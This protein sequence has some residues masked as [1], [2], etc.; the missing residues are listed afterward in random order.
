MALQSLHR[1]YTTSLTVRLP[2]H[3]TFKGEPCFRSIS[4]GRVLRA[5]VVQAAIHYAAKGEP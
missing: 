5:I 2:L 4:M 3:Y 1:L